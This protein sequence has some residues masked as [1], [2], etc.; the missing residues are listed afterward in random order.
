MEK[1]LI[2]KAM[3]FFFLISG[4]IIWSGIGL[5]GFSQTHWLLY[6]PAIFFSVAAISGI[7]PGMIVSNYLFGEKKN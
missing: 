7:C 5:T 4:L 2:S 6:I 1:Y 3:R